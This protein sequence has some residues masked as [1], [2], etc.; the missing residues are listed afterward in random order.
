MSAPVAPLGPP[1]PGPRSG[2]RGWWI[3][4]AVTCVVVIGYSLGV[5]QYLADRREPRLLGTSS[6]GEWADLAEYGFRLRVDEVDVVGSLPSRFRD[7][8]SVAAP[9]GMGYFQARLTVEV[10]VGP[11]EDMGCT[12]ELYN[13]DGERLDWDDDSVGVSGASGCLLFDD[14]RDALDVGDTFESQ[15]VRVV[16]P[17][18]PGSFVIRV[19][20]TYTNDTVYW[21]I[22]E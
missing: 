21:A 10:L 14:G 16:L 11:E 20:P 5:G 15:L 4:F 17:D 13:A 18:D 19:V 12:M 9:T 1:P 3:A 8:E 2:T 7:G 22:T 6:V